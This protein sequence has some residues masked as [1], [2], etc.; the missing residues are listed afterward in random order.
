M[1]RSRT[2]VGG[3]PTAAQLGN[4]RMSHSP[5]ENSIS[6]GT[7]MADA[8]R[9]ESVNRPGTM[10]STDRW[11]LPRLERLRNLLHDPIT[12]EEAAAL[13]Q[14]CRHTAVQAWLSTAGVTAG[15]LF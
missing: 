6:N 3:Q 11:L 8:L 5:E 2:F 1:V 10:F 15:P 13:Q 4:L 7:R 12:D 9:S 14:M